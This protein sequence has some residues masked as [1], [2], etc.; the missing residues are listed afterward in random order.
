MQKEKTTL[1]RG[2]YENE[3][4]NCF[5]FYWL[6]RCEDRENG[7]FVNCFTN[8]GSRLVSRDKYCWSQGRFVWMFA[9][10]AMLEAPIF[11]QGERR[12]F[13]RLAQ[14][15]AAFLMEHALLPDA[16][17][18]C[19]FLLDEKGNPKPAAGCDRLDASIYADCFVSMGVAKYGQ[20][21]HS[22]KAYAF[23]KK[24]FGS[25][26]ARIQSGDYFT[27]PYPLSKAYRAH[28]IPMILENVAAE[29]YQG[30][31]ELAPQ[32]CSYYET[33]LASFTEDILEHFADDQ[34]CIREVIRAD[35]TKLD[36]ILGEHIN[37]GHTMEDVWFMLDSIAVTGQRQRL[38]QVYR[39]AK[40]ALEKGWD[41]S[42]GG[43][44]HFAGLQG[45]KPGGSYAGVERKPMTLQLSGW[46]NKLWWVH[47]EALYMSLRC[48]LET[49]DPVFEDW[50]ERIFAYTYG[51][52]P[53]P[54]SEIREW[55]QIRNR[56]GSPLEEVVALPVKDPYH[57][58]RNLSLIL[59][60]LYKE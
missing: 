12:E 49:E 50:Y 1:L 23:A 51:T 8:D 45:G 59:E 40:A 5:L 34:D 27:L 14:Q 10:L 33:L 7:G 44:L 38:L 29:L 21:A 60:L 19:A 56:D 53:N 4:K 18:R 36:G 35:G 52:F 9:K 17:V 42:F 3:L 46:D 31:K 37:P 22:L 55:I 57:V 47:S 48:W 58:V 2:F 11:T 41:E 43:F 30:A 16:R 32:D 54:D 24:L 15:G 13:L 6:P 26:L 25:I 39:I 28:G 20:A